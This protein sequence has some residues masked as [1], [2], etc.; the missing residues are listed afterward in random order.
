MAKISSSILINKPVEEVFDYAAS[1]YN[2]PAFIPNLNENTNIRPEKPG[3]GQKF[4]WRFNLLGVDVTGT[5]EVAEFQRPNLVVMKTEGGTN[6]TWT[7]KFEEEDG[8]TRV[9]VEIEYD[10]PANLFERL[11]NKL[12][13]DKVNQRTSEQMLG[14]L[15][16]ILEG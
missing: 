8:G 15:K 12:V 11:T 10:L 2:G 1:P 6:S 16:T 3:A 9:S 7:Y 13:V 4:E 14:N 5:A